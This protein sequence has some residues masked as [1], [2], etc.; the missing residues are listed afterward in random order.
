MRSCDEM[1]L[2]GDTYAP[3]G[4][5]QAWIDANSGQYKYGAYLDTRHC[6]YW[7]NNSST[8]KGPN[9]TTANK[10]MFLSKAHILITLGNSLSFYKRVFTVN[11]FPNPHLF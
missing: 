7:S 8:F 11:F 2:L 5:E 4:K 10:I 1:R 9:M 6:A 3:E